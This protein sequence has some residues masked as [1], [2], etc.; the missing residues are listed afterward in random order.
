M[1]WRI[2]FSALKAMIDI[3]NERIDYLQNHPI[4]QYFT[5]FEQARLIKKNG[6]LIKKM[7]VCINQLEKE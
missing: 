7:K 3:N 5:L 4:L 2:L 6:A 1:D